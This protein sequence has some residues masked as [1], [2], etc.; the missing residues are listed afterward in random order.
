MFVRPSVR[1][2]V[3]PLVSNLFSCVLLGQY[4]SD[5]QY[6]YRFRTP[7]KMTIRVADQKCPQPPNPPYGGPKY[8]LW[9]YY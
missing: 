6:F 2:S 3:N 4:T 5:P 8:I 9:G 1:P 7:Y